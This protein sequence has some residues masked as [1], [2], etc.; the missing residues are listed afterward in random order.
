MPDF[1]DLLD[2]CAALRVADLREAVVDAARRLV[3]D[4]LICAHAGAPLARSRMQRAA[5]ADTGAQA[6]VIGAGIRA[7]AAA[8]AWLNAEAMNLLD[9][10][11]TFYNGGHFGAL[12]TAVALAAAARR[13]A[14]WE[15]VLAGVIAGFELN[16]RLHLATSAEPGC[17][18]AGATMPGAA[19]TA[20]IVAG[21]PRERIGHA[22]GVALRLAPTP[23]P[24]AVACGELG[25]MKYVPYG[26]IAAQALLAADLAGLGYQGDHR[27][28]DAD[29]GF[30]AMQGATAVDADILG[31][32]PGGHWWITETSLKPYP[33]FR[34]GHSTLG[35]L[36]A[37]LAQ[38]P[39]AP[40]EI[41]SIT[42]WIDPRARLL[43]FIDAVPDRFA[44]DHLAPIRGQMHL[45]YCMALVALGVPPGPRWYA[46]DT[47]ADPAVWAL[48]G[49]IALAPKPACDLTR[50]AVDADPLCGRTRACIARV[51]VR[52]SGRTAEAEAVRCDGDPWHRDTR[53]DWD[54]IARKCRAFGVDAALADRVRGLAPDAVDAFD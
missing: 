43:P 42:A 34:L 20:A 28:L 25:S 33:S 3:A 51:R 35:A 18:G 48:V 39:V 4:S 23:V 13:A 50:L 6:P 12:H 40:A 1:D 37:A 36:G 26:A 31:R 11:D 5:L 19:L 30:L 38:R 16:A 53:P 27:F 7:G 32:D 9:A 15:R 14:P 47:L 2:A 54:W 24:L 8:A 41:E 52:A 46:A 22:I 45:R 10:D 21:L 17:Y 44:P 49:R 29:G